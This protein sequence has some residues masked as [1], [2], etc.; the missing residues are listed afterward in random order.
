MRRSWEEQ[1]FEKACIGYQTAMELLGLVSQEI[2]SRSS[3]MLIANSI[4]IALISWTFSSDSDLPLFLNMLLLIVG[5]ILCFLWFLFNNH[6]VYWQDLFREKAIELENRYFATTFKLISLVVTESPQASHK[7]NSEIPKLVR[8]FPY[9]RTSLIVIF[10]F[11][12]VYIVILL[13]QLVCNGP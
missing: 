3:A 12:L 2:Y 4:I 13:Y 1:E 9:H 7:K 11:S 5:L 10:I 8:W 6:G